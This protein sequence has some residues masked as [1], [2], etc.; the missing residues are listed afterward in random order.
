MAPEPEIYPPDVLAEDE[1]KFLRRQKPVEIRRKKFG[2]QQRALYLRI[3]MASVGVMAVA[4]GGYIVIDFVWTSAHFRLAKPEQIEVLGVQQVTREA[5]L[6]RFSADLGRSSLRVPLD[7]RRAA[8]EEIPW[9]EKARVE[10]V[11]PDKLR[12]EIT[13]RTP[14]A[15]L[16][17]GAELALIDGHGVV[18]E[19]PL[20][21]DFQF[22]VI[23][24]LPEGASLEEREKRMRLFLEFTGDIER[25]QPGATAYVSEVD[26]AET[27]DLRA[28]LAGMPA[29]GDPLSDGQAAVLVHFGKG[30]YFAKFQGFVENIAHWRASAGRVESVDLRFDRQVVVNPEAAATPQS[31]AAKRN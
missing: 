19:R 11:L 20:Q 4:V 25:A 15:F 14:V 17:Q 3:L 18:L 2:K 5:V 22:P 10:R 16:R 13:E 8:L 23:T 1:P 28:T 26:L 6:E 24:G 7:E 30:N 29:L 31:A 12:V 21:A 9:V 27:D